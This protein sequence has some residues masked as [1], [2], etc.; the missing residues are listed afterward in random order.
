MLGLYG[1]WNDAPVRET[2]LNE[3]RTQIGL[4]DNWST[5]LLTDPLRSRFLM[6]NATELRMECMIRSTNLTSAAAPCQ[7]K[8]DAAE[9]NWLKRAGY[10]S[11]PRIFERKWQSF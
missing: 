8:S 10:S 2:L 5:H 1:A 7:F 6:L 3:A 9:L 11:L 4:S